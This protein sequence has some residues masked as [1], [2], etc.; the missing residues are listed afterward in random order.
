LE[1]TW[2]T[3]I[4]QTGDGGVVAKTGGNEEDLDKDNDGE[5]SIYTEIA[6]KWVGFMIC[7]II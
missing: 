5:R 4:Y 3:E 7:K 2:L 6:I 1:G